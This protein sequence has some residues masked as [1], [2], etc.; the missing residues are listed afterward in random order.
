MSKSIIQENNTECFI[1]GSQ[2]G[3]ERHHVIFG[4]AGRKLSERYGL[5]VML[6]YEHHRGRH[7]VHGMDGKELNRQLHIVA[8]TA[9]EG[10][11]G[12]EKWMEIIGKN[13]L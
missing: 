13:F 9:F 6:C 12:H 8:Q 7:G 4:T 2:Y 1:C 11:H 3:L 10:I 5:T